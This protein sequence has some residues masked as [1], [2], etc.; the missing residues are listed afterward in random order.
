MTFKLAELSTGWNLN[1]LSSLLDVFYMQ[2]SLSPL[3]INFVLQ[4]IAFAIKF[5]G[6]AIKSI[7]LAMEFNVFTTKLDIFTLEFIQDWLLQEMM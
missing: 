1:K 2:L 4:F 6:I 7:A 3:Q 5:V